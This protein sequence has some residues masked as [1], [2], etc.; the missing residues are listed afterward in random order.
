[1]AAIGV[2]EFAR[3]IVVDGKKQ[4][5][6]AVVGRVFVEQLVG[7]FQQAGKIVEGEGVAG[8]EVGLQVVH[9]KSGSDSLP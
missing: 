8:T 2:S 9:Q 5:G 4:R 3:V 1:M 6:I 7:G